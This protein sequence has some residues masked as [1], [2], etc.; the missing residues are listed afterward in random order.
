VVPPPPFPLLNYIDFA[1][2]LNSR[3][4]LK[5]LVLEA[6][7]ALDRRR[8][9]D[10]VSGVDL[11]KRLQGSRGD[12]DLACALTL[13]ASLELNLRADGRRASPLFQA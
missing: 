7:S 9:V 12:L 6:I 2:G 5:E 10:W 13:L 4:D 11:W 8:I 3:P 1:A